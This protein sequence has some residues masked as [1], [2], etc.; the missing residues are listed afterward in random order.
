MEIQ[1]KATEPHIPNISANETKRPKKRLILKPKQ[2]ARRASIAA[3]EGSQ[4]DPPVNIAI[5]LAIKTQRRPSDSEA[6]VKRKIHISE[7]VGNAPIKN[8]GTVVKEKRP[9]VKKKSTTSKV[10]INQHNDRTKNAATTTLLKS[11][12]I[13]TVVNTAATQATI[14][15]EVPIASDLL[16]ST[17]LT[18]AS[19]IGDAELD[20]GDKLDKTKSEVKQ[21]LSIATN[22]WRSSTKLSDENGEMVAAAMAAMAS[23]L[24]AGEASSHTINAEKQ[25]L[26]KAKEITFSTEKANDQCISED[27]SALTLADV[28]QKPIDLEFQPTSQGVN[29]DPG[30]LI[31]CSE[32]SNSAATLAGTEKVSSTTHLDTSASV[33]GNTLCPVQTLTVSSRRDCPEEQNIKEI[34]NHNSIKPI[35]EVDGGDKMPEQQVTPTPVKPVQIFAE[36][37]AGKISFSKKKITIKRIIR[38]SSIDNAT[39]NKTSN[40]TAAIETKKDE[41]NHRLQLSSNLVAEKSEKNEEENILDDEMKTVE[42]RPIESAI[43]LTE[44]KEPRKIKK[45]VIIKRQQRKLSVGETSSFFKEPDQPDAIPAATETLERAI[46]YVTDDEDDSTGQ[47][48]EPVQPI[49]S[50]MKQREY[51][52]GDWVMYGE[53]FRKTQ[54]R[55]KK[56]QIIERITSISYKI[57]IDDK[58]IS[59]HISYIKKYTGRR[60]N[61]G[62]KE[63]LEIDYEQIAEEERRART[64]SIWNMV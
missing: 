58:E 43:V 46:A 21:A 62:G 31:S 61:F 23:Q 55:W 42:E 34:L 60:V 56:G 37:D 48:V 7:S 9:P 47:A 19:A 26:S 18:T 63:Y 33:N 44:P 15:T 11:S 14:K 49:K 22:A 17:Q 5:P 53:R 6:I 45:K 59:A 54:I 35:A 28:S 64:Y 32:A 39:E 51:Q 25:P 30:Q 36:N 12:A 24:Q 3:T 57:K 52:V 16:L 1:S 10:D 38:K 40:K 50:C 41:D 29:A 8:N 20:S 27:Q 4:I 2:N 13:T